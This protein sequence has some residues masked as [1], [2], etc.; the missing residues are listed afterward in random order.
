[1][2]AQLRAEWIKL[3]STRLAY[4]LAAAHLAVTLLQ[5]VLIFVNAG[6]LHTPSLGTT[7]SVLRLLAASSYGSYIALVL[8]VLLVAGEHRHQTITATYIT[9]PTRRVVLGA[10]A[11]LAGA[12]G[13]AIAAVGLTAT[14]ALA[15]GWLSLNGVGL[16][17]G[18]GRFAVAVL[19]TIV[20]SAV[21]GLLG[22]G[23][24]ALLP[25]A[26]AAI[27][28]VVG[29]GLVVENLVVG[30]ALPT[31]LQWLPGGAAT[32]LIGARQLASG[33]VAP[34]QAAAVLLTYGAAF[35]ALG[36]AANSRRNVL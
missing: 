36:F 12:S 8:G 19:G 31:L 29:Y 3:R 1:M 11:L 7:E 17:L 14:A 2:T 25:N 5:V 30:L 6:R 34:A 18:H 20:V 4:G 10:K 15:V 21:Y 33:P 32:A 24:G 27:G 26:A 23:L 35:L 28:V 22:V 16:D 13:A 9:Q